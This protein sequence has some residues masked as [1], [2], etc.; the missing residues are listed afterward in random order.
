MGLETKTFC[1][2][3]NK[4][5]TGNLHLDSKELSFRSKEIK[6]SVLLGPKTK[7]KADG[8]LLVVSNGRK[9]ASFKIEKNIDRWVDKILNPPSR[10]QKL[11]IKEGSAIFLSTGFPKSFVDELKQAGGRR[12]NKIENCNLAIAKIKDRQALKVFESLSD[13]LPKGVNIWLVWPK[14]SAAITQ[15]DVMS[16]AKSLGFGP[17][18]TAAFDDSHSSMRFAAKK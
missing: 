2:T 11:G 9:K 12:V 3:A 5:A 15:G 16:A 7:A 17:S 18:K 14:G 10:S 13:E 4:Q 8:D 1:K 6:W